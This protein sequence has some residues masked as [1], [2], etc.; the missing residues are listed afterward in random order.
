M[1]MNRRSF[2]GAAAAGAVA[3][4]S[5]AKG[6]ADQMARIDPNALGKAAQMYGGIG[7]KTIDAAGDWR[8]SRIAELKKLITGETDPETEQ[9]EALVAQYIDN[10]EFD[11]LGTLKS[12]SQCQKGHM[13]L[14]GMAKRR[15]QAQRMHAEQELAAIEDEMFR[16]PWS[17]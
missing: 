1:A 13:L 8:P 10:I 15:A 17:G 9:R 14:A 7:K 2:F 5:M 4:P 16:F 11:R 6:L 12:V 3:G